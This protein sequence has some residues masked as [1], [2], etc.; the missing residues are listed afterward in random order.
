M[1]NRFKDPPSEI[2]TCLS[3]GLRVARTNDG[4][5]VSVTH[6]FPLCDAFKCTMAE[7]AALPGGELHSLAAVTVDREP[8]GANPETVVLVGE[9][10]GQA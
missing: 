5:R 10:R 6:E 2:G 3:C 7:I 1:K 8:F 9:K 4:Q